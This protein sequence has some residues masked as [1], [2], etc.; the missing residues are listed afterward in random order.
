[1]F[2]VRDTIRHQHV[3]VATWTL[4]AI[5]IWAFLREIMLPPRAAEQFVYLYGLVPARYLNPEW[6][7]QVGFPQSYWPFITM[8]FLHGGWLHI[9]GNMWFLGLFGDNV[10]DRMGPIR[11][12]GFYF[13]CGIAASFVHIIT[14]PRSTVPALG[15]SGAIAGVMAAYV[16]LYPRARILA[17]F[18]IIIYPLFFEVPATLYIGIWFLLQFF[19]GT[20]AVFTGNQAGGIAWWA[21]IGGFVTGLL[22]VWIFV[23]RPRPTPGLAEAGS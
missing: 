3:P 14:N 15:A 8:M 17:V 2:P 19:S 1:M 22:T 7:A 6:A 18:P 10:E 12:L 20:A 4:I 5:N 21:H 13:L 11:F 23:Q 16:V 9:I